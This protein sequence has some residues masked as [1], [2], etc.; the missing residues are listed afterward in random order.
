MNG[1]LG[2]RWVG[3]SV[4]LCLLLVL[5]S[6]HT[7]ADSCSIRVFAIL[8]AMKMGV[9]TDMQSYGRCATCRL[10]VGRQALDKD[11]QTDPP[12]EVRFGSQ[13]GLLF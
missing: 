9:W 12:S 11:G 4:G 1:W 3:R 6:Y 13:A 2:A 8:L 5:S 7:G 10:A